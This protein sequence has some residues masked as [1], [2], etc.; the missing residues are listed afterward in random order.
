MFSK[1]LHE[2]DMKLLIIKPK[3][4]RFISIA[5][6]FMFHPIYVEPSL[7][8]I[9]HSNIKG[10]GKQDKKCFFAPVENS[11]DIFLTSQFECTFISTSNYS[12]VSLCP[13][14]QD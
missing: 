7:K 9:I 3:V 11:I 6:E 13:F 5:L 14:S 1:K 8:Q 10:I 12:K 4:M 2:H